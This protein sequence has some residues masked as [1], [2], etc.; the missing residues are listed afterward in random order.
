MRI[1]AGEW[2]GRTLVAPRGDATRPTSDRVREALFSI[3]ADLDGADVLDLFAG[4]GAVALEA[5]SRGARRAV[6]VE[7]ARPALAA[8]HANAERLGARSRLEVRKED[9]R[10]FLA[11]TNE[12]FDLVF[13]DP[14]WAE[15]EAFFQTVGERA[16][17]QVGP[18][19]VLVL[20]RAK[21]SPPPRPL[22]GLEGPDLRVYGDTA[23][24]LFRRP[25]D[26]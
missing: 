19:G 23:L 9:V 3:L 10:R 6:C 14:P 13:A 22:H 12:V 2:R 17:A 15:A 1:V 26:G 25:S 21:R 20:E 5:L 24:A 11:S 4:T 7:R 16:A 8:L 18:K